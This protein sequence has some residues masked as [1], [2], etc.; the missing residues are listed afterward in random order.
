M[1]YALL[2]M[3]FGCGSDI[4]IST[5]YEEKTNDTSDVVVVEDTDTPS[6]AAAPES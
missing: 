4:L 3:L 5:K 1:K 6:P 2:T